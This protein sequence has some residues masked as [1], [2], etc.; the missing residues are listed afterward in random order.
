MSKKHEQVTGIPGKKP[1]IAYTIWIRGVE[2]LAAVEGVPN[3][4]QG[5]AKIVSFR[6]MPFNKNEKPIWERKVN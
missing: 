1:G 3:H 6:K 5:V 2:Y 4:P